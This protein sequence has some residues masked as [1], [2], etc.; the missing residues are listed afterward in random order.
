MNLKLLFV[1]LS[2]AS[3]GLSHA[4][5]NL[6]PASTP[7]TPKMRPIYAAPVLNN[8]ALKASPPTQTAD[9]LDIL[10]DETP[11]YRNDQLPGGGPAKVVVKALVNEAGDV[12][13]TAIVTSSGVTALDQAAREALSKC[14]YLPYQ[15]PITHLNAAVW[16]TRIYT[17][18]AHKEAASDKSSDTPRRG[19][20]HR[21]GR[22]MMGAATNALGN[23]AS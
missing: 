23:S 16:T 18:S 21:G 5:D 3:C 4:D 9:H 10:R 11:V 19:G 7:A 2:L 20:G 14:R 8:Q 17:L 15:D 12:V 1:A 13:D 22:G 6:A